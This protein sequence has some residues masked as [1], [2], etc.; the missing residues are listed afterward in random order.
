MD[1]QQA[2]WYI[3]EKTFFC[4]FDFSD[5]FIDMIQTDKQYE[6][7]YDIL[8][9]IIQTKFAFIPNHTPEIK[10]C[11][12]YKLVQTVINMYSIPL[13]DVFAFDKNNKQYFTLLLQIDNELSKIFLESKD[14]S[15]P[16]T[17]SLLVLSYS[18]AK[19]LHLS[20]EYI[21]N[22]TG[23]KCLLFFKL[24]ISAVSNDIDETLKYLKIFMRFYPNTSTQFIRYITEKIRLTKEGKDIIEIADCV[25]ILFSTTGTNPLMKKYADLHRLNCLSEQLEKLGKELIHKYPEYPIGCE[26][27]EEYTDFIDHKTKMAKSSF[28]FNLM[29]SNSEYVVY[30][31]YLCDTKSKFVTLIQL[32][33]H[34]SASYIN[35]KFEAVYTTFKQCENYIMQSLSLIKTH[36]LKINMI[37]TLIA[38]S[39]HI[40]KSAPIKE[41]SDIMESISTNNIHKSVV[42]LYV[43][44]YNMINGI[45]QTEKDLRE[46]GFDIVNKSNIDE[47]CLICY[48]DIDDPNSQTIKGVCCKKQLGHMSCIT[49]WL[50]TNGKCPICRSTP[51]QR[52]RL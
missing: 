28:C 40:E 15:G 29:D 7:L 45:K 16:H 36:K 47:T 46:F 48:L 10:T 22:D 11:N 2:L 4:E 51:E 26:R 38:S 18:L 41:F 43:Q 34:M 12:P 27:Y 6:G 35:R 44:T 19:I 3:I 31:K 17:K 13:Y 52:Q 42:C 14:N 21:D 33:D 49:K 1:C 50:R 20:P 24:Y 5:E 8:N 32:A 39:V 9:L 25:N 23:R 30:T 37:F